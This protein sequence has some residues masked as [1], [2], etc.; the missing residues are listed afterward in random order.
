MF[1]W[2]LSM[3]ISS[4]IVIAAFVYVTPKLENG[5]NTIVPQDVAN[6]MTASLLLIFV[7]IVNIILIVIAM[8]KLIKYAN[9]RVEKLL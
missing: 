9:H 4:I 7:P 8:I 6:W 5:L 2:V 3:I 1:Y